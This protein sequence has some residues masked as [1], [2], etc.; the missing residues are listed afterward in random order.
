MNDMNQKVSKITTEYTS[1]KEEI[2]LKA[3]I[4]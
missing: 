2:S 3:E 1:K 4:E